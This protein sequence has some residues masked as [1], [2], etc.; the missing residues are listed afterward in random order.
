MEFKKSFGSTG[1]CF[2]IQKEA[3]FWTHD[4]PL[5]MLHS[6]TTMPIHI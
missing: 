2:G 1:E 6:T 5:T 3:P 4:L